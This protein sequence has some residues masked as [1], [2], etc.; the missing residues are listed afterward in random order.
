M[1][2]N[3][4]AA[5]AVFLAVSAFG[6]LYAFLDAGREGLVPGSLISIYCGAGAA[7]G[8]ARGDGPRTPVATI[9]RSWGIPI[10]VA[11]LLALPLFVV[12]MLTREALTDE[13]P[14]ILF[15]DSM[16]AMKPVTALRGI[17]L[18]EDFAAVSARRGP[19]AKESADTLLDPYPGEVFV[20]R[21]DGIRLSVRD[22]RVAAIGYDCRE[23]DW[24]A[25]NR[26][27]CDRWSTDVDAVF[28]HDA[29]A[30]CPKADRAGSPMQDRGPLYAWDVPATG[31]RYFAARSRVR[32]FVITSPQVLGVPAG[33]AGGW[34]ACRGPT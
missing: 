21:R 34:Q 15:A 1:K 4:A 26:I 11:L 10:L 8:I 24:T 12:Y 29:T 33:D 20:N 6:T 2:P 23:D 30:L 5:V 9:G 14:G 16:V 3:T 27:R 17:R 7:W 22:G 19:F 18:G 13:G 28:R 31:T 32:G 25:L